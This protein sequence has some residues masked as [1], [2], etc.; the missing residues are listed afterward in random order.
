MIRVYVD[1]VGDLFHVGHINLFKQARGLF[2]KPIE[3]I[4]GVH[5]DKDVQSYKR[6]PIIKEQDRYEV[7]RNCIL[8]D[9]TIE[10]APLII[11]EE[12]LLKNRI[13]FVVHGDDIS[14]ELKRQHAIPIDKNI[15]LYVPY[16]SGVSTTKILHDIKQR[17]Q[18]GLL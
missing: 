15:V 8:V 10:A 16:T 12:F 3:L 2:K 5:C 9:E 13:N 18:N 4:V 7:V 17:I 11:S 6:T 1:I 14:E